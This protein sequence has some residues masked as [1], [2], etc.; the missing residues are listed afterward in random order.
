LGQAFNFDLM[1]ADFDAAHF[2][3]IVTDNLA[4]SAVTGS[5]TTWVFSNH[6]GVRHATRYGLPPRAGR[7][8]KQG[9]EWLLAGGP[10]DGIDREQGLRRARAATLF[11]LALPGSAYLYQGEE[12]GLHEVA[13][14]PDAQRQDHAFWRTTAEDRGFDGLGRDGC[15]VPPPG[16][17]E[18]RAFRIE[19]GGGRP[20]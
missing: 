2:R 10:E 14:I 7:P 13:E 12:L 16:P 11:E 15:R 17:R 18:G 19:A 4:Q 9:A 6:D 5:S 8:V 1:E 3:D 20:P